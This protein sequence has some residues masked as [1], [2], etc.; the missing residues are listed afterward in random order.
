MQKD[1][2]FINKNNKIINKNS[3][4]NIMEII[5]NLLIQANNFPK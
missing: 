1:Q 2:N 4:N 5:M 3:D